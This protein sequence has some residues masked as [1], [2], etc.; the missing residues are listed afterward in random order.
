MVASSVTSGSET[1]MLAWC[2]RS[3]PQ[4]LWCRTHHR[5]VLLSIRPPTRAQLCWQPEFHQV[6]NSSRDQLLRGNK[7]AERWSLR[8]LQVHNPCFESAPGCI[9]HYAD[10]YR[11]MLLQYWGDSY[12]KIDLIETIW[13]YVLFWTAET[14][15]FLLSF[16]YQFVVVTACGY[17][18][19]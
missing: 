8:L 15:W 3:L 6:L 1:N 11:P 14:I 12:M 5:R 13:S 9:Y 7:V 16:T 19:R 17:L 4:T 2:P 18:N 10:Y